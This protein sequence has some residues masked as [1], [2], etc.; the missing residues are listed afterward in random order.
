MSTVCFLSP[1]SD[2]VVPSQLSIVQ[3]INKRTQILAFG[4]RK[5]KDRKEETD[6]EA[7]GYSRKSL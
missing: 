1:Y 4:K 5:R 7:R 6:K 3:F 2:R